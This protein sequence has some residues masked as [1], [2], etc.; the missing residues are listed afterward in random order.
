MQPID[1]FSQDP[2]LSKC[3]VQILGFIRNGSKIG[4][5][6]GVKAL[7]LGVQTVLSSHSVKLI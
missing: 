2:D 6:K 1:K 3:L 5:T 7:D 4:S